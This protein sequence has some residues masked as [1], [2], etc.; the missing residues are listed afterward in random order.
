MDDL[1][2]TEHVIIPASELEVAV[3]RSSGPG[4]QNVN[5]VNSKVS[6]HWQLQKSTILPE[7]IKQRLIAS[8]GSKLCQDGSIQVT[9]QEHRDQPSNLRSCHDKLRRMIAEAM[10]PVKKR[11]PTKP[12]KAS[13]RRR[14]DD[15]RLNSNKK[16]ARRTGSWES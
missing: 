15:K 3:A 11:R 6:I 13:Q 2:I 8:A 14:M 1:V 4:G 16:A 7:P 9:S 10:K 12:S 5:K